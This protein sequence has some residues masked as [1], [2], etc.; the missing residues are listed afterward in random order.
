M[1]NSRNLRTALQWGSLSLSI[2]GWEIRR[3]FL[4]GKC[5]VSVGIGRIFHLDVRRSV[6]W[7]G[8]PRYISHRSLA[9]SH[10]SAFPGP[11]SSSWLIKREM[12]DINNVRLPSSKDEFESCRPV[13]AC[14]AS[15]R[16]WSAGK[17]HVFP[18]AQGLPNF[19]LIRLGGGVKRERFSHIY[20]YRLSR[21]S[22]FSPCPL[23]AR[24]PA[25]V[26]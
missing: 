26:A 22:S 20:E 11:K 3:S 13:R 4:A 23:P 14:C 10:P 6:G 17:R 1:A 21:H 25:A 16:F 24:M 5:I 2:P 15:Y 9:R 7:A 18:G 8:S 19:G 12:P